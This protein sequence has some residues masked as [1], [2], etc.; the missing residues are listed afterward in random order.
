MFYS[1]FKFRRL[2]NEELGGEAGGGSSGGVSDAGAGGT[3]DFDIAGGVEEISSSLFADDTLT[4]T[5]DRPEEGVGEP[6]AEPAK[7]P[8]APAA[9]VPTEAEKAAEAAKAAAAATPAPGPGAFPKTWKQTPE[10]Q[11]KWATLDPDIKNEVA[12]REEAMFQGLEQYKGDA[13]IGKVMKT[14]IAPYEHVLRHYKIDPAQLTATLFKAHHDLS[15]GNEATRVQAFRRLAQDYGVNLEAVS[16]EAPY[17][18]PQVRTLREENSRLQSERARDAENARVATTR[19]LESQLD[20][21][22]KNPKFEFSS[23]VG[24]EMV[25][26]VNQG[27]S[28]EEAYEKAIWLNPVTRDKVLAK[29]TADAKAKT[30]SEAAARLATAKAATAA[31]VKTSSRSGT[32]TG[33]TGSMEDTMREA[34]ANIMARD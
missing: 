2:Q 34:Y 19:V 22:F 14:V 15:L 28:L 32:A 6:K 30:E 23:E 4:K 12:R 10:L 13:N 8:A 16:A 20:S 25:P 7:A 27:M 11:A 17:E 5:E 21:F 33:P 24:A 1:K 29:Q 31:N 26:F 18:D 9:P 3:A